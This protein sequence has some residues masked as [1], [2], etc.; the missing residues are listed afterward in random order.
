MSKMPPSA[1]RQ[2]E[3]MERDMPHREGTKKYQ[4][5]IEKYGAP[6][7]PDRLPPDSG[8][9]AARYDHYLSVGMWRLRE[10]KGAKLRQ[11]ERWEREIAAVVR[12]RGVVANHHDTREW[13][14]ITKDR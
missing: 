3:R 4:R 1:R 11:R 14:K 12:K 10:T 9:D 7:P 13:G 5:W 2:R 8:P 6:P